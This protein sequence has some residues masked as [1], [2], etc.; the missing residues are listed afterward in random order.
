MA[1]ALPELR[2]LLS[3]TI[4]TYNRAAYLC[5][6][7][8][9]LLPQ[10]RGESRVE[11]LVS[12]NASSDGTPELLEGF[13]RRGLLF[14]LL[15]NVENQGSDANFLRCL[16]EARGKYVWV[17]GDDDLVLP[18]AVA[19][20]LSLLSQGERPVTTRGGASGRDA[21][22]DFDL[23]YLSSVGFSGPFRM[24]PAA[25]LAD[26]LGRFAEVVTD[27]AYFVEKVNALLGLISV[28]L[29]NKDRLLAMPHPPMEELNGTNLLQLGWIF[30]LLRPGPGRR[31]RVLYV[32]QRLV[33]YRSFN[34][35]GWGVCEV[36]GVRLGAIAARYFG[37]LIAGSARPELVRAVMNGVLRYWLSDK[38][39]LI[40]TGAEH[41]GLNDE[42]IARLLRP[43]YRRNW[44]YWV[45][46]WPMARWPLPMARAVRPVLTLANRLT[47]GAQAL[48]RHLFRHGTYLKP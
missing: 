8:D 28:V 44:R 36:F 42:D 18:T 33:A 45:F 24:P 46:V 34:S 41:T 35:T 15:R 17:L 39:Y 11:L 16:S 6:L 47:R 23:V 37:G 19:D 30:P 7:L 38:I 9:V 25:A 20:L 29:V 40:R 27:D 26:R 1:E 4:P 32:W 10:L 2:P 31:T 22:G 48:W 21:G 43:L 5:E 13:A 12:D 14:R 3:I